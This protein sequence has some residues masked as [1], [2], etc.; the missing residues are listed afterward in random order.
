MDTVT[1][2]DARAQ[3]KT[4]MDRAIDDHEEI[5][6]S[7]R[8]GGSVVM[9]SLEDW[10]AMQ[11]TLHL[12]STPANAAHLRSSIEELDAGEGQEQTLVHP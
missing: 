12:L 3:L 11:E 4:M 6:I 2:S 7:R 8:N 10:N 1:Y 5:V 9:V